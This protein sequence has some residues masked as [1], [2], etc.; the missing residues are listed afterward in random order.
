LKQ[1]LNRSRLESIDC[2]RG[3]AALAVVLHHAVRYSKAPPDAPTWFRWVF[4]V[5]DL[6]QLG[7]PLFFVLSGFCIHLRWAKLYCEGSRRGLDF[8]AFWRRR[9]FRLYPPYLAALCI[10]MILVLVAYRVR[11]NVPLVTFYP[12]PRLKWIALD[13]FAHLAMLHGLHPIFDRAG[14]NP[15]FWTLAREEY[16]YLMYF[17]LLAWRRTFGIISSIVLV[18]ILGLA[19]PPLMSLVIPAGSPW[20]G[21]IQSSAIVL[22]IQWCL[23]M[24]AVE[25]YYGIVRLPRWCSSLW[26]VPVWAIL[27]YFGGERISMLG[28]LLWGMTFFT[29]LNACVGRERAD[30]WPAGGAIGWVSGVGL[31]SYSLYLVH[32]PARA[33][34]RYLL[35]PL[36]RTTDPV[37]FLVNAAVLALAGY[38]AGMLFFA[39]VEKRFLSR[40]QVVAVSRTKRPE[41]GDCRSEPDAL[42][43]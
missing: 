14:G 19:F 30:R 17:P 11:A 2:L 10:S 23:G 13:F 16:F 12:E 34:A 32:N 20:W 18:V 39:L 5:L 42:E 37:L 3:G 25:A 1:E 41:T 27:A 38:M 36:A 22:W 9:L 29:L 7:V 28:P 31:F 8:T 43:S 35:G 26:L 24:V 40:S 4:S 33:V 15:P 6:G 21:V